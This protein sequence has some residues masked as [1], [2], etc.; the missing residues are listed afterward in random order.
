[1]SLTKLALLEK[2]IEI[3]KEATRGGSSTPVPMLLEQIYNKLKE[4]NEDLK[5]N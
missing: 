4:L 2:T 3:T 5:K 1:M